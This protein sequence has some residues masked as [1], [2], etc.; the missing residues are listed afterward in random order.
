[1]YAPPGGGEGCAGVPPTHYLGRDKK[2][3]EG[4]GH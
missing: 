1:M 2:S 4:G 3:E